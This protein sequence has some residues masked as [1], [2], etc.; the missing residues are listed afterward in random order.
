MSLSSTNF[1]SYSSRRAPSMHAGSGGSG[2]VIS[3]AS[4]PR[5]FSSASVGFSAGGSSSVG[6]GFNLADAVDITDNKKAAMQNLN[7]RLAAYL[8]KVRS[9]E[10]ANAD[11]ELKIRHFLESKSSPDSRDYSAYFVTIQ[12]LQGKILDST[13]T[14]GSIGL[15]ID[16]AKL[17][18]DDFRIKYENELNMRQ[19]V[20]ADIV[21]LRRV[22]DD[23]TLQRSDLEMLIEGLRDELIHLKKN[24]EED[25]LNLRT[26]VGGQVNVEVD[27]APQQDLTAV[28]SEIREHYENV[29]AKKQKDLEAWFQAKSEDITK[30]VAVSTESI[31]S[32]RSEI[33]ELKRTLQSL[34][35]ELQ[36]QRSMKS[37]LEATLAETQNRYSIMLAGYQQQVTSL[38]AQLVQLKDD[39][40]RQAQEYQ[41]LLDI[42]T[43]LQQEIEEY[44]RLLDGDGSA[45]SSSS[46]KTT[47]TT[48]RKVVIVT[49]EIVDGE[50]I[51]SDVV[52]S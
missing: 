2:V 28:M 41:M 24:H 18:A 38:E 49:K 15:A 37:S 23:L 47:T 3:R 1:T 10:K 17:A 51:R 20:E 12:D 35:I 39:L 44:R 29:A 36:S 33:T 11:L 4:A 52:E 22:L 42:K 46:S 48:T 19:G 27:A 13:R 14:N 50:E 31:Q 34:E 32:S 5:S 8:Q 43:R 40:G 21:G 45:S 7:D 26:Q 16:N 6:G 9:L 25:L 30:E